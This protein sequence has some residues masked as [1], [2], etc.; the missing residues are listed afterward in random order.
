MRSSSPSCV[1]GA[2]VSVGW[3]RMVGQQWRG[4]VLHHRG[5]GR[6]KVHHGARVK[7]STFIHPPRYSTADPR[8][9]GEGEGFGTVCLGPHITLT[10]PSEMA[11]VKSLGLPVPPSP[12]IYKVTVIVPLLQARKERC[13]AGRNSPPSRFPP[14]NPCEYAVSQG[15]GDSAELIQLRVLR[16]EGHPGLPEC[17]PSNPIPSDK[18]GRVQGGM[19]VD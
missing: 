11:L 6:V 14:T 4:R 3:V 7:S 19:A 15:K 10:L 17:A 5:R 1:G 9:L 13:E 16:W 8:V 12:P 18:I 2:S